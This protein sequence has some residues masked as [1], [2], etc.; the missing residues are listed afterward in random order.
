MC[1]EIFQY[2]RGS[3]R[4]ECLSVL[5]KLVAKTIVQQRQKKTENGNNRIQS[6]VICNCYWFTGLDDVS[7]RARIV[8]KP[9]R[10]IWSIIINQSSSSFIHS[11]IVVIISS[12]D[13]NSKINEKKTSKK[14]IFF[15]TRVK[16][17]AAPADIA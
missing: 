4:V 13:A 9:T 1:N 15:P 14:I 12:V 5:P 16:L 6:I 10:H 11:F 3:R 17:R 7:T 2:V 8:T